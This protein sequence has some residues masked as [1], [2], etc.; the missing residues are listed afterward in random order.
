[1]KA[2]GLKKAV[3]LLL[4]VVMVLGL[5]G[6]SAPAVMAAEYPDSGITFTITTDKKE[7]QPGEI[8]TL[9]VNMEGNKGYD[10][11]YSVVFKVNYDSDVVEPVY[12][13]KGNWDFTAGDAV[14]DGMAKMAGKVEGVRVTATFIDLAQTLEFSD[15]TL[16][17]GQFKV[18]EDAAGGAFDFQFLDGPE[19]I[20]IGHKDL[21]MMSFNIDD[22]TEGMQVAS[23]VTGITLDQTSM[24]L[25]K[26]TTGKLTATLSPEGSTGVIHWTSSNDNVASVDQDG[27]VSAKNS[28]TVKITATVN[29]LSASCDVTVVNPLKG[30]TITAPGDRHNLKKGQTLQLTVVPDPE[31]AEGDLT[32]KWESLDPDVADVDAD[33]LVTAKADGNTSIRATVGEFSAEY[34]IQVKEIKLTDFTLNKT[35][36]TLHR[37]TS[38]KLTATPIPADTTDDTRVKWESSDPASVAVDGDGNITA[39]A[40]GGATITATMGGFVKQCT[41]KVDAPLEAII[42][43]ETE[44]EMLKGQTAQLGY[45]L[46]PADTTDDRTV[47]MVS[48]DEE[49]VSVDSLTRTLTAK[50]AGTAEITLTGANNVQAAVTVHVKE[51]PV[52]GVVLD[53]ASADV[54]KGESVTLTAKVTPEDTT[55]S[56]KSITWTSS[57]ESIVTVSK[58]KTE[59]GESVTVTATD[60][61]GRAVITAKSANG[62]TAECQIRVPI[63]IESIE[64]EGMDLLRGKTSSMLENVT[65]LP[66]N[67]DDDRTL[68]WTSSDPSTASIDAETGMITALKEGTVTIT[69]TTTGTNEPISASAEVTV[70]ENRLTQD[71]TDEI[72]FDKLKDDVLKGQS[73]YMNEL[74]NLDDLVEKEQI[75]D[76]ITMQWSV[77][78]DSVAAI[79]QSGCLTGLKEGKTTV[80]VL[81]RATDGSGRQTA[82]FPVETEINVKEIPLE[83]IAFD[84]VIREMTVGEKAVLNIIYNPADTTDPREVEW[85]TS[86][87]SVLAVENGQVTAL[88]AG[89]ATITAK[90]GKAE[91]ISMEIAVKAGQSSG[92]TADTGGAVQTGDAVNSSWYLAGI[93]LAAAVLAATIVIRRRKRS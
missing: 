10:D 8:I 17:T 56:D 48:S 69:A 65:F 4:A 36:T 87:A 31:D 51:I 22:Q 86:D 46:D 34:A 19:D 50:K 80:T 59:S 37:G 16:F 62:K 44:M 78:D 81:I 3:A 49:V 26:G 38:E 41:V 35:E 52:E 54:E 43:D 18:K 61:G 11:I 9:T 40:L 6:V 14:P 64:L 67:A 91:P 2:A 92:G 33:G 45:E 53:K 75:T 5:C 76:D 23:P 55:D 32:A 42:P 79:D 29:G 89:K 7:V 28:G 93:L 20:Q 70:I 73:I 71:L 68:T 15:G 25:D 30:I 47:T 72:R 77:S 74:L 1:M 58:D 24:T 84:K 88:K 21:G 13:E 82:E 12:D 85:S 66:E 57:D 39:V 27:T 60:K 83:S 90:V 63:H